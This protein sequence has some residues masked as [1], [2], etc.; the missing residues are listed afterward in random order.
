M[1]VKPQCFV[2]TTDRVVPSDRTVPRADGREW[3]E[4]TLIGSPTAIA[5]TQRVL[6]LRGFAQLYEWSPIQ[7]A[8]K[9]GQFISLMRR[10]LH[11]A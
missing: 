4:L 1:T 7:P 11:L 9:T 6:Q 8:A 3:I 5:N 2:E 10:L